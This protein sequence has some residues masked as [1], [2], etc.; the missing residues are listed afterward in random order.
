MA[1]ENRTGMTVPNKKETGSRTRLT[2]RAFC[3]MPTET[4]RTAS[5]R[6]TKLTGMERTLT[7][8]EQSR[9]E[10]G[11]TTSRK[12]MVMKLGQME[13]IRMGAI[14]MERNTARVCFH[15]VTEVFKMVISF[16][17]I[18][19]VRESTSGETEESRLGR[20]AKTR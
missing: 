3:S 2:G 1:M 12:E 10:D 6:M 4:F 16:V 7:K 18:L 13:R 11:W 9:V 19:K 5:G 15:G 17:T 20:G 14:R 8:T